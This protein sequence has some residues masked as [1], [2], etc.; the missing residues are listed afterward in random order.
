MFDKILPLSYLMKFV[1]VSNFNETIM[2]MDTQGLEEFIFCFLCYNCF[3]LLLILF[4]A[5]T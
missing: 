1:T 2:S 4:W 5:L 3:P